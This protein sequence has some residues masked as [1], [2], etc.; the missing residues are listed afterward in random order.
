MRPLLLGFAVLAGLLASVP[1]VG[2]EE[3]TSY[4]RIAHDIEFA[5]E[6]VD[7]NDWLEKSEIG[8]IMYVSGVIDGLI[9]AVAYDADSTYV[10]RFV[11]CLGGMTAGQVTAI[12]RKHLNEHPERWH[13]PMHF[14]VY[15]AITN[16][17]PTW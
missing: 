14:E 5:T 13:I 9:L 17:C 11:E 6:F 15:S 8:K 16:S 4:L 12:V 3:P 2:Q 1:V 10:D 7:G